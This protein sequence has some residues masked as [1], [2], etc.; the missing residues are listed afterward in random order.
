MRV[1]RDP[2]AIGYRVARSRPL[3]GTNGWR[4]FGPVVELVARRSLAP[5]DARGLCNLGWSDTE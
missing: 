3:A 4:R 1:F 5:F 2:A